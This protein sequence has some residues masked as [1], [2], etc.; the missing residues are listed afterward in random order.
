MSEYPPMIYNPF[1]RIYRT[2]TVQSKCMEYV[3]T[4]SQLSEAIEPYLPPREAPQL[5]ASFRNCGGFL[6]GTNSK[7]S[8]QA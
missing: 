6:R 3:C 5:P 2:E 8:P 1:L 7:T 4:G